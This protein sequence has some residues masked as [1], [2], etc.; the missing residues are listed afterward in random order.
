MNS[1]QELQSLVRMQVQQ[2]TPDDGKFSD[3]EDLFSSELVEAYNNIPNEF[4]DNIKSR[5]QAFD[6]LIT[7]MHIEKRKLEEKLQQ[8]QPKTEEDQQRSERTRKAANYLQRIVPHFVEGM[9]YMTCH[10]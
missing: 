7:L 9:S 10:Y 4:P 8:E 5:V 6:T 3:F 2:L 1:F